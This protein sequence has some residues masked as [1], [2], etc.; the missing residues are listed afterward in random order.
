MSASARLE[1][2]EGGAMGYE[3]RELVRQ[4]FEVINS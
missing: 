3:P 4:V 2:E 1:K